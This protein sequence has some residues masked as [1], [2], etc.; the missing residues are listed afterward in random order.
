MSSNK[1]CVHRH[2]IDVAHRQAKSATTKWHG[3]LCYGSHDVVW[4]FCGGHDGLTPPEAATYQLYV[5]SA[6][7]SNNFSP[8]H[9]SPLAKLPT[10]VSIGCFMTNSLSVH[11][12]LNLGFSRSPHATGW[13]LPLRL[14]FHVCVAHT[15][16]LE[17]RRRRGGEEKRR[18]EKR[19]EEKRREEKRREKKR[20]REEE[21]KRR[22]ERETKSS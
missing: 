3:Q 12:K 11:F 2:R 18:E 10:E 20:E 19:R 21:M 9:C 22:A 16:C 7:D 8:H 17:K 4:R 13:I 15:S 14:A 6:S 1:P 5:S